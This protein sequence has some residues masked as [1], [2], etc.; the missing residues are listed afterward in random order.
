MIKTSILD[1]SIFSYFFMY[2]LGIN[3]KYNLYNMIEGAIKFFTFIFECFNL[4]LRLSIK[5]NN[6]KA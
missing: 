6:K 4:Y 1:F 3:L 2:K 5:N